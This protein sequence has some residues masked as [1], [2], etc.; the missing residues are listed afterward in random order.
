MKL[1]VSL[2]VLIL[3]V[4]AQAAP[5]NICGWIDNPTPANYW[6]T[7]SVGQWIISAQGGYQAE[8]DV[9]P[10]EDDNQFVRTNGYYGYYCG[11]VRATTLDSRAHGRRIV[12]IFSS[13]ALPLSKCLNDANL[14]STFRPKTLVHSSGKAYTECVLPDEEEQILLRGRRACVNS[15]NEYYFLA[16]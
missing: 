10:Q 8:G 5:R 16:E 11:C 12:K 1:I 2:F 15:A 3:G 7:D 9:A 13:R 6:I 14:K 4:S